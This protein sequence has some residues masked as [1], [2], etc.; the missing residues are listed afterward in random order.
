M[1]NRNKHKCE[2]ILL[3]I[4]CKKLPL[5]YDNLAFDRKEP[6]PQCKGSLPINNSLN[7]GAL[8]H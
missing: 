8:V 3:K 7:I 6:V 1:K 5:T 2:F 4:V